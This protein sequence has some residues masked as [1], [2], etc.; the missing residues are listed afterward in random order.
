M[1]LNALYR[2]IINNRR[3]GLCGDGGEQ[4]IAHFAARFQC[5]NRC[6]AGCSSRVVLYATNARVPA[7]VCFTFD[8]YQ[9]N[10][11]LL[12]HNS[13][14]ATLLFERQ[15]NSVIHTSLGL[16]AVCLIF[17]NRRAVDRAY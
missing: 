6:S 5:C 12:E 11:S 15:A 14:S 9:L 2:D 3:E 10:G 4:V 1:R 8:I 16:W 7:S 13:G 17:G